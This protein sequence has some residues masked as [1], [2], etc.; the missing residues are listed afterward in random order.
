MTYEERTKERVAREYALTSPEAWHRK[1]SVTS[2]ADQ[3][4]LEDEQWEHAG[5]EE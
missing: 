1:M 2:D 5:E 3:L 4:S